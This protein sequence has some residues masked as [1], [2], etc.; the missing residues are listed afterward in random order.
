M[1]IWQKETAVADSSALARSQRNLRAASGLVLWSYLALH[2]SNHALG[3]LSVHAANGMRHVLHALWHSWPGALALYGALVLHVVLAFAALWERRSLRMPPLEA[4]RILLGL[5]VPLLLASHVAA[6]R[7]AHTLYDVEAP[8][9][10]VIPGLIGSDGVA[11]Q[12][13]LVIV[14]WAHGC[15]GLHLML[16][17]RARYQRWFHF[18]FAA[19]VLL[20]VLA[21]LGMLSMSRELA[22]LAPA[23]PRGLSAEQAVV[24]GRLALAVLLVHLSALAVLVA[25]RA[26]RSRSDRT[27]Q[28]HILL[29]YPGRSVKVPLGWSVLEASRSHGLPHMSLCGG[30]AR[31]STCRVRVDGLPAHLPSASPDEQRTLRRV[32]APPGV[33]LACQLRPLGDLSVVPLF[34]ASESAAQ[35]RTSFDREV[36]VL[37]VDLRGWSGLAERQWPHDLMYVL[38]RYFA[39]VGEAVR[40]SGGVPNQFIGDSVMAMYPSGQVT[41]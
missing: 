35:Q 6:T 30:R 33:R 9:E 4:V 21:A 37:F 31:C 27:R 40:G 10:R 24:T 39:L 11:L 41:P 13:V 22:A 14:A 38:D 8:Y 18:G 25:A 26:L 16:V 5:A 7:F 2:L 23:R 28:R 32:Q 34:T 36:A 29:H 15:I 19:A 1:Q 3:L 17:N 12:L 20:P